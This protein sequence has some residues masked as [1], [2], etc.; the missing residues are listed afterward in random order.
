MEWKALA[1]AIVHDEYDPR[2]SCVSI[3]CCKCG[4]TYLRI[5]YYQ[6]V[7]MGDHS[8][9]TVVVHKCDDC[10]TI[11]LEYIGSSELRDTLPDTILEC[12]GKYI[13]QWIEIMMVSRCVRRE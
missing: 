7:E 13:K 9:A 8:N 11:E 5:V 3:K 1:N 4:N 10:G 6:K 12:A 2:L